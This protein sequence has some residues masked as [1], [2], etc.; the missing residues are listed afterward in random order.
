MQGF[1]CFKVFFVVGLIF[2]KISN[3]HVKCVKVTGVQNIS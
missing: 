2:E 1:F 3:V